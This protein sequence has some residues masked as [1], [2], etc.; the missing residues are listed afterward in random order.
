M[1]T[2]YKPTAAFV[3]AMKKIGQNPMLSTSPVG[4]SLVSGTRG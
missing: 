1:V 3:K 4:P 2:L